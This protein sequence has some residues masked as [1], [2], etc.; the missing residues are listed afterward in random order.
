[1]P[2]GTAV[3]FATTGGGLDGTEGTSVIKTTPNRVATVTLTSSV[4][5]AITVRATVN[6]VSKTTTVTFKSSPVIE[7][8][9]GTAPTITAVT[10]N[11][12]TPAGGQRVTITGTN[13]FEPLKV[14]FDIGQP[15]PVQ[16][17]IVSSTETSIEVI[18]PGVNIAAGQQLVAD[19]IVLTKASTANEQRAELTGGLTFRNEQLTPHISTASPN[20]GPVIGG[21]NVTIFGDG[22]QYPVQVLFGAAEARV[23][24]VDYSQITVVAPAARDTADDGSGTVTGQVN[25]TV[26]NINS[27]REATMNNGFHYTAAMQITTA[28]PTEGSFTGGTRVEIDGIGFV[29][30]V[31]VSIGGVA[32]QP[33]FVSGTKVIALTSG[34]LLSSCGDV[35]GPI[36]VTNTVNGDSATGPVFTYRVAKPLI[37]NINPTTVTAGGNTQI[38]VVNALPGATRITLG[39]RAVFPSGASFNAATGVTT[40]TVAVPTNFTFATQAC[41]SG[42]TQQVPLVV[43]VSYEN[44]QSTC[45]DT[46]G[47]AL[48]V[49]PV[50]GACVLPPPAEVTQTI[51]V[52]PN[53]ADVGDVSS[54]GT[55]TGTATITFRNDGGQALNIT[56]GS[57]SGA[58]FTVTPASQ[59]ITANQSG[60]FTVTFD[61]AAPGVVNGSVTFNTNDADEGTIIVCLTGNGT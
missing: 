50:S 31:A 11:V 7:P 20:S 34:V 40:Y 28:G 51:P 42:G 37:V 8:P 38:S 14:L 39:D 60:S 61:P 13:F 53:C 3:E 55:T 21:T 43:D 27:Q 41:G 48:T 59:T 24:T 19:V 6:N 10:P 33:V 1:V 44:V 25:I 22:F 57:V 36:I 35:P 30:P 18:T 17:V 52:P 29:A 46:A 58:G 4:A 9:K 15:L 45:D 12:T 54:A 47:Q 23:L 32:A 5:T 2:N 56:R 26:R 49:N 16:G